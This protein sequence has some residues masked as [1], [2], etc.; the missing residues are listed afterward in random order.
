MMQVRDNKQTK[1]KDEAAKKYV[2]MQLEVLKKYGSLTR[3]SKSTY[4][5]IVNQVVKV[6]RSQG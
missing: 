3:L 5:T 2:D 4:K 1:T 6:T